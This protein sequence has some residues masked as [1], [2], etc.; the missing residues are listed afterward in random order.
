MIYTIDKIRDLIINK[1]IKVSTII[2]NIYKELEKWDYLNSFVTKTKKEALKLCKEL[3][4]KEI[5]ENNFLDHI[6]YVAKDNFSTKNILTTSSS[7]ILSDYIPPF[8]ATVINLLNT[9][10]AILLGKTTLDELGMG[11]TGLTAYNGIVRNPLNKDLIAGGSS[12]GSAA[13][14]ATGLIPFALGTDTGDSIRKPAS[15]CGIVGLKPTYGLI[16]RKGLIPYSPSFDTVGFFT[17]N[18]KDSARIFQHLAKYDSDDLTS[19]SDYKFSYSDNI[20]KQ[21]QYK[22]I[23]ISEIYDNCKDFIKLEFDKLFE[24]L[25]NKGYII[26]KVSFS[27][28]LLRLLP[29]VYYIITCSEAINSQSNLTG[30]PFGFKLE[31]DD[32][33]KSVIKTRTKCLGEIVRARYLIGSYCESKNNQEK[34]F[35]KAKKIRRF[36]CNEI[37]EIYKN[38]DAIILPAANGIA[39]KISSYDSNQIFIHSEE[40]VEN[41]LLL[42]NFNGMPSITIPFFNKDNMPIGININTNVFEEKKLFNLANNIE[43]IINYKKGE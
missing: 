2:K 38:F 7:K 32:W 22:I 25:K 40:I 5:D 20:F 41:S 30:I 28:S 42:A 24:K 31:A 43:K 21:K 34:L 35:L 14:V 23:Y 9:N 3:D 36:I 1:K 10:N 19:I 33:K 18:V 15:Y 12:S 27:K 16:S 6:P 39:P 26:K 17:N 8:N 13:L 29:V 4:L 37:A 11:G